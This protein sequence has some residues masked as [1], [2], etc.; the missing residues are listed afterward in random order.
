MKHTYANAVFF[1]SL[2]RSAATWW[3]SWTTQTRPP[4]PHSWREHPPS[5]AARSFC[6]SL[7]PR[8]S[9]VTCTW[10]PRDWAALTVNTACIHHQSLVLDQNTNFNSN[11]MI[12]SLIINY[13]F[14]CQTECKIKCKH[15]KSQILN[16]QSC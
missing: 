13:H 11:K 5:R 12:C 10:G 6:R 8:C 15:T 1:C 9:S 7:T 14:Q 2:C 4:P 3:S 16:L